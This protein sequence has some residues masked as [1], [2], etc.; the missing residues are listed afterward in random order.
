MEQRQRQRTRKT[1]GIIEQ[2]SRQKAEDPL[3]KHWIERKKQMQELDE[4]HEQRKRKKGKWIAMTYR[5][6]S[7]LQINT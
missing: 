6:T 7:G 2:F 3:I 1:E 5:T 4:V